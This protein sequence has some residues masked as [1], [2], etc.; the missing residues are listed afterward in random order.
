MNSMKFLKA[1]RSAELNIE[2]KAIVHHLYK[3]QYKKKLNV[4]VSWGW[5]MKDLLGR[6]SSCESVLKWNQKRAVA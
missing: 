2:Q 4:W 1:E 6:I 5:T 3:P